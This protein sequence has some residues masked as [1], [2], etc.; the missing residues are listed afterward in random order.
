MKTHVPPLKRTFQFAIP[1][2]MAFLVAA[3][4]AFAARYYLSDNTNLVKGCSATIEIKVD[5][6][7]ANVMAGDSTISIS[8]SEVAVNQLTIGTILPMQVFNQYSADSIRLSGARLPLSGAFNGTGIFGRINFT[9]GVNAGSGT[10]SFSQDLYLDN[11]MVDEDINNVLTAAVSKTYSFKERYNKDIDGVGFCDPDNSAPSVQFVSPPNNS[12]GHPVDT[13]IAIGL[14]DNRAGVNI[15]SLQLTINGINYSQSSSQVSLE[16]DAHSGYRVVVNPDADFSEGENVRIEVEICDSNSPANCTTRNGSFHIFAPPPPDPVCGDGS[17]TY[18]VG[19]QCDDSNTQ[20]GDGCS[21]ICLWEQPGVLDA[22]CFDS[23]HNQGEEGIDC[24]GPCATACP[25][26]VDGIP[27]QSEEGVDCGGPC[28]SC[29]LEVLREAAPV[30]ECEVPEFELITVCHYPEAEDRNP[31]SL[32]IPDT[33]LFDYLAAGDTSGPCSVEEVLIPV[34]E[35]V[36]EAAAEEAEAIQ[37]T[38]ETVEEQE[39]KVKAPQTL[40]VIDQKLLQCRENPAYSGA[41][42]IKGDGTD[43]DEDGV[44]DGMECHTTN[45][46]PLDSDTDGDGCSDGDEI[47]I[48]SSDPLDPESSGCPTEDVYDKVIISDPKPGWTLGTRTP[49]FA[50]ALPEHANV[51]TMTAFHS[52]QK[53]IKAVIAGVNGLLQS[54]ELDAVIS[55]LDELDVSI[56]SATE[57]I[58]LNSLDFDYLDFENAVINLAAQAETLRNQLESASAFILSDY[59]QSLQELSFGSI[60]LELGVLLR[61]PI[62]LGSTNNLPPSDI[63]GA[64]S[65]EFVATEELE[66]QKLYNV[67]ATATFDDDSKLSSDP[68]RFGVNTGFQISKPVPRTIGGEQIPEEEG[69]ITFNGQFIPFANAQEGGSRLEVEID[70]QRPTVTGDSEFGAQ[71]FAIWNSVVLSSSVISDSEQGAFEIQAPRNLEEGTRHRVTL[72]AVKS[73]EAATLRSESVD[74]YFRIKSKEIPIV[75]IAAGSGILILMGG[76]LFI[77]RRMLQAK[78]AVSILGN[79]NK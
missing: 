71:V 21:S 15:G 47:N 38:V 13:N 51:I 32:V 73:E 62:V 24:G 48:Y 25:T 67:V 9:P 28:P 26:C 50:G 68:I 34:A 77:V 17:V 76:A 60:V 63:E 1:L 46:N 69:G 18:S 56:T 70:E 75:P 54:R 29:E 45:T 7:G 49:S 2:A 16:G 11:N 22:S 43:T 33:A 53:L 3:P 6:E 79:L 78:N 59:Y 52:D 72:Y 4:Q 27:N 23:F 5:T 44:P 55:T 57:F 66:D 65:Y 10:F 30:L 31:Y 74:V 35:E 61:E 12:G 64:N 8:S 37:E 42:F 41:V 20:D 19:E 40:D 39:N 14:T 36:E 58:D